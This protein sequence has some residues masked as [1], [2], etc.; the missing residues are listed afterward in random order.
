MDGVLLVPRETLMD[1]SEKMPSVERQDED[2]YRDLRSDPYDP[3]IIPLPD[4]VL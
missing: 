4:P 2:S 1:T 3:V